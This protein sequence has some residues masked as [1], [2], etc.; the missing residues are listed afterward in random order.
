MSGLVVVGCGR[1]KLG[2][3]AQAAELYTG[4]HFTACLQTALAIA[5]PEAVRILS[6]KHGLVGL[7]DELDP[8]D[9]TLG[10]PGAITPNELV[11]QAWTAGLLD[12]PDLAVIALCPARYADLLRQV[13]RN[14][15]T[16]LAHL[17]IGQQR[18][19][20]AV[21]R[22]RGYASLVTAGD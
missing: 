4:Q 17:G 14:V 7:A 2:H 15:Y 20:L 8:Y 18:H 22:A 13:W 5:P 1:G 3:R 11:T 9:V 12:R 19:A 16:P 10:Q 6:A 21:M